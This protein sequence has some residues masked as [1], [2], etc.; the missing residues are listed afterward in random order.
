MN[1]FIIQTKNTVFKPCLNSLISAILDLFLLYVSLLVMDYIFL[2]HL[3]NFL[4]EAAY[5]EQ[6]FI[7]CWSLCF[8]LLSIEFVWQ[9]NYSGISLILLRLVLHFVKA[10]LEYSLIMIHFAW[11]LDLPIF[12]RFLSKHILNENSSL[13]LL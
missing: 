11:P 9:S 3:C 6:Q 7:H 8:V 2:F 1:I 5:F 13:H 4:Q 10:R 12:W